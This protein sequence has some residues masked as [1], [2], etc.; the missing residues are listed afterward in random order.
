M[1][2][3]THAADGDENQA[4][5]ELCGQ[6]LPPEKDRDE[7]SEFNDQIGGSEHE[8]NRRHEIDTLENQ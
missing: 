1:S 2:L 8:G 7:D 6:E 4:A 5:D 3:I